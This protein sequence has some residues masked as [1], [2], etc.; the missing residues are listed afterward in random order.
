M[1][2]AA[3]KPAPD[4]ILRAMTRLGGT[5]AFM[6]GDSVDDMVA[7]NTASTESEFDIFAVGIPAPES[8]PDTRSRLLAA[9]A[10]VVLGQSDHLTDL[11]P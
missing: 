5:T 9:G 3:T 11:L 8:S 1:E 2:D 4:G 7:A 10:D 6:F